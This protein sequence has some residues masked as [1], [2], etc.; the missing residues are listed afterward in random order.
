M[1]QVTREFC[2]GDRY[3]YDWGPC[4]TGKGFAQFDTAQDAS[5]Y[6]NWLNPF[7]LVLFSFAEG[8]CDTTECGS[9]AEFVRETRALVAWHVEH[10]RFLGVD[11]GFD[12]ALAE[13]FEAIGLGDL[14]H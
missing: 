2:P 11:P 1:T 14:L 9:V 5:Y 7:A 10:S 4:S 13:R 6:G 3:P 8:D 12:A